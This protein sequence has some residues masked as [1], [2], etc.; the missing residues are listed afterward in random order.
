M[1][2][3][4]FTKKVASSTYFLIETEDNNVI[5]NLGDSDWN[6]NLLEDMIDEVKRSVNLDWNNKYVFS[7]EDIIVYSFSDGVAPSLARSCTP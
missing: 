6:V 2:Y 3:R 4:F 1:E 7:T 5:E